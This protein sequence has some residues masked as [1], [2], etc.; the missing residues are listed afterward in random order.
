[1]QIN[2][3]IAEGAQAQLV[4]A[5]IHNAKLQGALNEKE[6]GKGVENACEQLRQCRDAKEKEEMQA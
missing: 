1:M 6:K 4:L 5:T 2:Q 3:S